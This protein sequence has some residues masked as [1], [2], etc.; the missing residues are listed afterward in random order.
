M[1]DV[2]G[3]GGPSYHSL[4]RTM[5]KRW[6]ATITYQTENGPLLVEHSMQEL[7]EL[8]WLVE[9]GPDW[10]TIQSIAIRPVRPTAP[11][12]MLEQAEDPAG[13]R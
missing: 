3:G 2:S 1:F 12:M 5:T 11:N 10:T 9:H 4:A 7:E 8:H 13:V 6:D